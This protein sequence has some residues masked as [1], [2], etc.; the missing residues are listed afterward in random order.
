MWNVIRRIR[1]RRKQAVLC[2]LAA[3]LAFVLSAGMLSG[4]S[5]A[6]DPLLT[7][8]WA[9]L[10]VWSLLVQLLLLAMLAKKP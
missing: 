4:L 6:Q 5:F 7:V 9:V 10:M 8:C 2:L 1:M 3:T